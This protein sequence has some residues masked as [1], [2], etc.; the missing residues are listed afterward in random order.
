MNDSI[1]DI[2]KILYATDL[3][4]NARHAFGYAVALAY[5]LNARIIVLHVIEQLSE[6]TWSLVEDVVGKDRMAEL[7][8]GKAFQAAAMIQGR[9][10]GFCRDTQDRFPDCPFILEGIFVTTGHPVDQILGFADETDADMIIMGSRGQSLL[11]DVT[12]GSTSRR[13]LR[14]SKKPV[15]IVRLPE[16]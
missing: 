11:A 13:V 3:S 12:M 9:L 2:R 7:K 5:R 15:L 8:K 4:E 1:P 16:S 14:R 6:F 10:E